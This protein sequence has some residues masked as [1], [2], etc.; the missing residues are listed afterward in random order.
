MP[1]GE[2]RADLVR[3]F[4]ISLSSLRLRSPAQPVV[5]FSHGSL[6]AELAELCRTHD[7]MVCPQP[8]YEERLQRSCPTGGRALSRY[9]VLHKFLN[10]EALADA[11]Y[12]QVLCCDLDTVF[13]G[14]VGRL[15]ERYGAAAT[16][17]AREEV[18]SGRS[19]YGADATFI[20][21][22]LLIHVGAGLG[23]SPL[24]PFNLGV[25]LFNRPN[26]RHLAA[27]EDTFL[28]IAW[29]FAT[30]M[31]L[32]PVDATST[33]AEFQGWH[34]AVASMT[35]H[36]VERALPFPSSNRWILD[37]AALWLALGHLPGVTAADFSPHDVAQ[38]G[39][40][41]HSDPAAPGWTLCH[42]FSHSLDRVEDWLE[43]CPVN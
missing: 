40:F 42:Y 17:V 8:H 36:D 30:W 2:V 27:L 11:G 15:F 16:V 14:D 10:F 38:N 3:Q 41:A 6:P 33:Y 37:E 12:D 43:L 32:H 9:P 20:D 34:E 24:P 5:L 28:D 39:E 21:E 35:T 19:P 23:V 25:V 7:V 29:R 22:R 13:G 31:A 1:G 4:E 26:W 18:H